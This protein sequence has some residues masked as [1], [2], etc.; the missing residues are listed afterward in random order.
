MGFLQCLVL[1]F[2]SSI[3]KHILFDFPDISALS[4]PFVL[5]IFTFVTSISLLITN[6]SPWTFPAC[7]STND[8]FSAT[9]SY[10]YSKP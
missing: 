2:G 5:T 6:E 8:Y 10:L 3:Q 7:P 4:P 1:L 9:E